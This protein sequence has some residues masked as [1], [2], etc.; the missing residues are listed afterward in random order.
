MITEEQLKVVTESIIDGT[1]K[2]DECGWGW[3]IKSGEKD[4]YI[5]HK[6]G[7]NNRPVRDE[8]ANTLKCKECRKKFT[9]TVYKN[10]KSLPIC[11]HCGKHN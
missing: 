5:C 9:Q 11:P 3:I 8:T 10:K 4:K 2:C 6:C 1:V 7:H